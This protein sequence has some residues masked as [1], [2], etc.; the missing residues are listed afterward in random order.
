MNLKYFL[1]LVFDQCG[2]ESK[3]EMITPPKYRCFPIG[4]NDSNYF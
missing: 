2:P 1:V 4:S 3:E